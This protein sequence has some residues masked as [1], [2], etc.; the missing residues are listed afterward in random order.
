MT[1]KIIGHSSFL[2]SNSL[3]ISHYFGE[4]TVVHW[5]TYFTALDKHHPPQEANNMADLLMEL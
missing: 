3:F 5:G 1:N 2:H 4:S